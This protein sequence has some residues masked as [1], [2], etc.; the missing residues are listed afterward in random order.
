MYTYL[1][2]IS[3]YYIF[4]DIFCDTKLT[5]GKAEA[6]SKIFSKVYKIILTFEGF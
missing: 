6:N 1:I 5:H 3:K 4:V 2:D